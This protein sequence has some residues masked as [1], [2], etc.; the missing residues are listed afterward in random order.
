MDNV[1]KFIISL[2]VIVAVAFGLAINSSINTGIR[3][4]QCKQ[5]LAKQT[6]LDSVNIAFIC[7]EVYGK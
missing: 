4:S 2:I 7:N 6:K 5:E 1:E 3:F